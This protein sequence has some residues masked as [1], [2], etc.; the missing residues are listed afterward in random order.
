MCKEYNGWPN[1]FTWTISLYCESLEDVRYIREYLEDI[2][3]D[4]P[5]PAMD[6]L[7]SAIAEVDWD[8]LEKVFSPAETEA[9]IETD[10]E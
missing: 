8:H 5:L 9:E 4:L 10:T 1:R 7:G 2:A 3:A 6:L